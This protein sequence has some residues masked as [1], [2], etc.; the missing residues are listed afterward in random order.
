MQHPSLYYRRMAVAGMLFAGAAA[1]PTARADDTVPPVQYS[2][3]AT[4]VD[5]TVKVLTANAHVV[6]GDTGYLDPTGGTREDTVAQIDNPPPLGL[7]SST[8]D[9]ITSGANGTASS[10]A[11]VEKLAVTISALKITADVIE[12]DTTAVCDQSSQTVAP[13]GSSTIVN[14]KINGKGYAYSGKP[15][16]KISIPGVA[17]IILNEQSQ[18]DVNSYSVNAIHV[19]VP[20][21]PG[22]ASANVII[23]HA[24][25][26]IVS[27][28]C[29]TPVP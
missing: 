2:G 27:C 13:S 16:Q 5:A 25:S 19:I 22:V 28:P 17:T 29:N 26:G 24:E 10:H 23:S 6:L 14:L 7:H 1:V 21:A 3:R 15:N 8:I 20:G 12:A 18:P 4:V 11:E 9:A